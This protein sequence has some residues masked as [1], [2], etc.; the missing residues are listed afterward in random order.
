MAQMFNMLQ[1]TVAIVLPMTLSQSME[2]YTSVLRIQ[3]LLLLG[4]IAPS[5]FSKW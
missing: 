4:T 5:R 3:A 2:A 1:A